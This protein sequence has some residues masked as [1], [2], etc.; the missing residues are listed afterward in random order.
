MKSLMIYCQRNFKWILLGEILKFLVFANII[1][2]FA[3]PCSE[4]GRVN[5][6]LQIEDFQETA[7][8]GL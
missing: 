4:F 7:K 3:Q 5:H 1:C 8:H 6:E 2:E